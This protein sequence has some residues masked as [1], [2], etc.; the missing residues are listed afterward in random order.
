MSDTYIARIQ[1][2]LWRPKNY[3]AEQQMKFQAGVSIVYAFNY[4]RRWILAQARNNPGIAARD[5]WEEIAGSIARTG[6]IR[7]TTG[8][9]LPTLDTG[10]ANE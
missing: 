1:L 10:W 9:L 3:A 8:E 2:R 4:I 6:Q 5:M 7:P